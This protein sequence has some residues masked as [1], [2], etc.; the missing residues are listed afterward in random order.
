[1]TSWFCEISSFKQ[2]TVSRLLEAADIE[3]TVLLPF[4]GSQG[5]VH[6]DSNQQRTDATPAESD[7]S[8]TKAIAT[9][10]ACTNKDFICSKH[11]VF[12][13]F[14]SIVCGPGNAQERWQCGWQ[15]NSEVSGVRS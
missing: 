6:V 4:H 15:M 5:L 1:M 11:I 9:A 12:F 2:I 3:I 8:I 7:H 14:A 10:G 13:P